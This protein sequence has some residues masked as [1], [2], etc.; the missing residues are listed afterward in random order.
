MTKHAQDPH[1]YNS[2]LKQAHANY[3]VNAI[4]CIAE[5]C[6]SSTPNQLSELARWTKADG[7]R[8]AGMVSKISKKKL[9]SFA[10]FLAGSFSAVSKP[11]FASKHAFDSI[12]QALQNVQT[13]APLQSQHFTI[14]QKSA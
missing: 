2:Y 8:P 6:N 9:P 11:V 4:E 10:I 1:A 7:P 5:V 3:S 14:S 12:F 13:F